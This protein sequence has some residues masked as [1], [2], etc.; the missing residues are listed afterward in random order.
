MI[1]RS[2]AVAIVMAMAC[3]APAQ[4]E[5]NALD[6]NAMAARQLRHSPISMVHSPDVPARAARLVASVEFANDLAPD[7]PITNLLLANVVYRNTHQYAASARA[8]EAFLRTYGDDHAEGVLWIEV[9]LAARNSAGERL[10]FLL[11]IQ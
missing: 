8:A 11:S 6:P 3:A 1:R 10:N 2:L 4:Q 5:P 7:D 9:S